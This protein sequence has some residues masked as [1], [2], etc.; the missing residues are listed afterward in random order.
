VASVAAVLLPIV[1]AAGRAVRGG[2][3][4]VGDNGILAI[5]ARDVLSAHPP[6]LG[7]RT[8]A[9]ENVG[10]HI[11][12]LGPLLFDLL[13]LP[14]T[15][16]G[17]GPGIPVGVALLNGTAVVGVAVVAHRRGGPLLT[18]AAMLWTGVLA[19]S[20]GSELLYSPWQPHSLLLPFLFFSMLVWSLARADLATFPWLVGV[21]SLLVQ[22]HLSY[23]ILVLA[24]GAWGLT[25]LAWELR[26]VRRR[27]PASWPAVRRRAVR[28]GAL[29]AGVLAVTWIRPLVEQLTSEGRGN[30]SRLA[31]ASGQPVDTLGVRSGARLL[32][33][34][35]AMPP[36]SSF[37]GLTLSRS[38]SP[39]LA[40][41][42]LTLLTAALLAC[43]GAAR[44][45]H[46]GEVVAAAVTGLV[47][48]AAG[49][50][51]AG[52][53]PTTGGL[54][55]FG[56]APH[57]VLWIWPLATFVFFV[58]TVALLRRADRPGL[59]A[60][61]VGACAVVLVPLVALNLPM[62]DRGVPQPEWAPDTAREVHR[63][64]D[65]LEG[66]GTLLVDHPRGY[67]LM[68]TAVMTELQRR[69]IPFVLD[70]ERMVRQLGPAR[71][72]TGG[73]ADAV[74]LVRR[75]DS[76]GPPADGRLVAFRPG[77]TPEE[78]REISDLDRRIRELVVRAPAASLTPSARRLL[79][80]AAP[81]W[82][83]Q[84]I[85]RFEALHSRVRTEATTGG[86]SDD[87]DRPRSPSASRDLGELVQVWG[88]HFTVPDGWR[89]PFDRYLDLRS[90]WDQET[91]A[92]YLV[93][94][95]AHDP[96]G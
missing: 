75:G 61:L 3:L 27:Q 90:R 71:A 25:S 34:V 36:W 4:P 26:D 15:V 69:G 96:S 2:W 49:L 12:N 32:A 19:W 47:A 51:T 35:V 66:S 50:V 58:L 94:L 67:D 22:T 40:I 54:L 37:R 62:R 42:A 14:V 79:A 77:L 44:R 18:M 73:N 57:H 31:E 70:D 65:A 38:P 9:S 87:P 48:L 60:P 88:D 24:L 21:A 89:G 80:E 76:L 13:A 41:L 29:G 91:V 33:E 55:V 74:L 7:T 43:A 11:N 64:M 8:S 82:P 17:V 28:F 16:F 72:F 95:D 59:R 45:R 20:M 46:D 93:P 81:D 30:L 23:A 53:T 1:L 84:Q 5:R 68:G 78:Q 10:T 39:L 85:A 56:V 6:M 52:R 92:L 86:L 83:A 63:Q